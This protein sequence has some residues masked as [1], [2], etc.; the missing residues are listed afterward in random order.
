MAKKNL[1]YSPS[2]K[3]VFWIAGYCDN[4]NVGK[5]IKMLEKCRSEFAQMISN[6]IRIDNMMSKEILH[7]DTYKHMRVFWMKWDTAP[8]GAMEIG[9]DWTMD[10]WVQAGAQNLPKL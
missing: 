7:S 2:E 5:Q 6:I 3:T 8:N 1:Y 10:K 9:D 4:I